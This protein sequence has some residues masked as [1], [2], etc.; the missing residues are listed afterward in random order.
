MQVDAMSGEGNGA[1]RRAGAGASVGADWMGWQAQ[2][3]ALRTGPLQ[4]EGSKSRLHAKSTP[5]TRS[6]DIA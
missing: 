4:E 6:S 1:I 3:V 5:N 2:S